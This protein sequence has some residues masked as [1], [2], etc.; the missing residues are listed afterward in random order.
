MRFL[1]G[2][3]RLVPDENRPLT[4][5][6]EP[7][8]IADFHQTISITGVVEAIEGET[9]DITSFAGPSQSALAATY[10]TVRAGRDFDGR[11]RWPGVVPKVGDI[12]RVELVV[13]R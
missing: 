12:V 7:Y 8:K 5:P 1:H 4:P 2:R 6:R 3:A 9:V 11:V 10:V 13:A